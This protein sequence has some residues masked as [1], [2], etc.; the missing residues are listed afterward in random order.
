ML[1]WRF[2]DYDPDGEFTLRLISPDHFVELLQKLKNFESMKVVE[3]FSPQ[4]PG[5]Q[6]EIDKIPNRHARDRIVAT[7]HDDED[8]VYVLRCSGER[9]LYGFLRENVFHILWWDPKHKI[10]PS[11]KRGT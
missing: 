1:A 6:Y 3:A 8:V 7:E 11:N 2:T 10:W 5:K 4:G 9:R